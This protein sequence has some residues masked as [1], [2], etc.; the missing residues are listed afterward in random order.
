M[1]IEFFEC[2]DLGIT[3][4]LTGQ[5]PSLF[6]DFIADANSR[7][8]Q[9][10]RKPVAALVGVVSVDTGGD[11]YCRLFPR[12]FHASLYGIDS[13]ADS[14]LEDSSISEALDWLVGL[15]KSA[16]VMHNLGTGKTRFFACVM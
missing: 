10:H 5:E 15:T 3:E 14:H 12:I 2:S 7:K 11:R 13:P 1:A 8:E 16:Q 9:G 4:L 6:E